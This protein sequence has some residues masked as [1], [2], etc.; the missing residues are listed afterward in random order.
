V[1]DGQVTHPAVAE[2]VGLPYTPVDDVLG[3]KQAV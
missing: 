3:T 1:A 2:G